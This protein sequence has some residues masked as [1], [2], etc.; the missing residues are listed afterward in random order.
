MTE[1]ENPLSQINIGTLISLPVTDLGHALM[2]IE[3]NYRYMSILQRGKQEYREKRHK[4]YINYL[5]KN[6]ENQTSIPDT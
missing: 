2:V 5:M 4:Y 6:Y 1:M 3:R